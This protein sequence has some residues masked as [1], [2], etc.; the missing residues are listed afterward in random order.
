M[1][2]HKI[3]PIWV[4][5]VAV[6]AAALFILNF[7]IFIG[8]VP[9]ESM[10]PT[11]KIGSAIIGTRIFCVPKKGDVIIFKHN[12]SIL[13]KRVAAVTGEQIDFDKLVYSDKIKKP[14]RESSLITVPE[15]CYFVLGDN[16]QNSFDSRYWSDP[17][18]KKSDVIAI[19]INCR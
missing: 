19:C 12:D 8:Y 17:F 5:P 9:S 1:K 13:V 7:V 11:I 3:K 10:S 15:N 2:S 16:T 14:D 4:V 6:T 18:V